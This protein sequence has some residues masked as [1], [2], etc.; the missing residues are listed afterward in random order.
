MSEKKIRFK[1][2]GNKKV[3]NSFVT[4]GK[5]NSRKNALLRPKKR[6]KGSSF[7]AALRMAKNT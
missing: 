7:A 5:M 1:R 2:T 4:L 6:R 3:S